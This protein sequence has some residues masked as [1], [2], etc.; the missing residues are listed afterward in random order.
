LI[1]ALE[2]EGYSHVYAAG[3][4]K[5]HGCLIAFKKEMYIKADERMIQ[6]DHQ[7]VR[8]DGDER[9]RRGCSFRT[10]NIASLISLETR[11]G[12]GIILATTHLFW[13]PKYGLACYT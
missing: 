13:H 7:D 10:T 9:A 12:K 8:H 3:P 6:Y 2:T 1:P 4:Q 5:K 11:D